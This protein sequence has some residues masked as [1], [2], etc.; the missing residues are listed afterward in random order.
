MAAACVSVLKLPL[1]CTVITLVLTS[2]AGLGVS[3]LI[4]VAVVVGYIAIE[5][6]SALRSAVTATPPIEASA[7]NAPH[8]A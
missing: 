4:V 1:S 3:P 5:S 6:L 8:S 7:A 2:H